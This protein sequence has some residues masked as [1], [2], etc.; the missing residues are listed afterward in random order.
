MNNEKRSFIIIMAAVAAVIL[1]GSDLPAFKF[2]LFRDTNTEIN[3]A[4]ESLSEEGLFHPFLFK[5]G[6]NIF[7]PEENIIRTDLVLVLKE[8]QSVTT[9][10]NTNNKDVLSKLESFKNFIASDKYR[11]TL[12]NE[13]YMMTESRL[14]ISSPMKR[15]ITKHTE[16][17]KN[18]I[19]FLKDEV[20]KA[21]RAISQ[22]ATEVDDITPG[23]VVI[24]RQGSTGSG[25]AP[26]VGSSGER[27]PEI[28]ELNEIKNSIYKL[29]KKFTYMTSDIKSLEQ[30]VN[31]LNSEIS[32][33]V[34]ATRSGV[35]SL[36]D[37]RLET[38]IGEIESIKGYLNI[39]NSGDYIEK[40]KAP[41]DEI[42]EMQE[43]IKKLDKA[44]FSFRKELKKITKEEMDNPE[45]KREEKLD[46]DKKENTD[47]R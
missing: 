27:S 16:D 44:L 29:D 11:Y 20:D 19:D 40:N 25:P 2:M 3:E 8:I 15:I 7:R 9:N 4:S 12:F 46:Y 47:S 23:T 30:R 6:K 43:K 1:A 38:L 26:V 41:A 21:K 39:K 10:L 22:L 14:N 31:Q 32:G 28:G 36:T 37:I 17:L 24:K 33:G 13:F 18:N 42:R 34:R 45:D 5:Y 35:D